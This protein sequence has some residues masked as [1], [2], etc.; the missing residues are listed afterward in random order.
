MPHAQALK[1]RLDE[2]DLEQ[3]KAVA[4]YISMKTFIVV[5]RHRDI[6][7]ALQVRPLLALITSKLQ[8]ITRRL[9][10]HDGMLLR[11]VALI[12]PTM[13]D[14]KWLRHAACVQTATWFGLL[15]PRLPSSSH[16]CSVVSGNGYAGS[17]LSESLVRTS[18]ACG[19]ACSAVPRHDSLEVLCT[20]LQDRQHDVRHEAAAHGPAEGRHH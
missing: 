4:R 19:K 14:P 17:G 8:G 1:A 15:C 20:D 9:E 5:A 11:D 7:T 16:C 6:S 18:T 3:C 13:T 2:C 10:H 12:L